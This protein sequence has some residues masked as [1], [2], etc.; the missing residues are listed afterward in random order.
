MI[1][2]PTHKDNFSIL[3]LCVP[4]NISSNPLKHKLTIIKGAI[5]K[6]PI[7][8]EDIN[9]FPSEMDII[10]RRNIKKPIENTENS[11]ELDLIDM[12]TAL[13][14]AVHE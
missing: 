3:D 7:T 13:Q 11:F 4:N 1:K 5:S 2:S 9:T 6:S 12:H 8:V 10:G 14:K